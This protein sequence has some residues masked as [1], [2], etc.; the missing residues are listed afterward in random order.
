[1]ASNP[2]NAI[3]TN[4]GYGGRTSAN[5]FND[6]LSGFSR[7]ILSGWNCVPNAGLTLSLGGDGNTRDV[8]I[9]QDNI[10]DKVTINNIS[11]APVDITLSA[12][13]GTNTRIDAIVAYVDNPPQGQSTVADNPESCG[14]IDVTG[15]PA[16]SP[17]APNDS[18]IRTAITADGA[19]G[20]TAYYVVLAYVTIAAGTTD[21]DAGMIRRGG[22]ARSRELAFTNNARITP[23]VTGGTIGNINNVYY[24]LNED[25]T[26]GKIYGSLRFTTASSTSVVTLP[27]S[28]LN[29]TS[30][31]TI[32]SACYFTSISGSSIN[33]I[34]ARDMVVNTNGTCTISFS[35][36]SSGESITIWFPPCIYFFND[37]GDDEG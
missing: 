36:S 15:I 30:Q 29:P 31:F 27:I 5:A 14:L 25:G 4:A 26:A 20:T 11:N 33:A 3:G 28:G 23:T 16:A 12:A 13:P 19:S 32:A 6:V 22:V 9:A 35:G 10:G 21:I 8:A 24:A 37:F 17:V 7:G 2:N 34:N 1:M 18:A